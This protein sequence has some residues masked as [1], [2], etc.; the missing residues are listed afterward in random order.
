MEVLRDFESK[1]RPLFRVT[2]DNGEQVSS[3]NWV[4]ILAFACYFSF[5][6]L[7]LRNNMHVNSLLTSVYDGFFGALK[8]QL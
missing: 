4:D 2:L 1:F 6:F 8:L 7:L 5:F 3:L